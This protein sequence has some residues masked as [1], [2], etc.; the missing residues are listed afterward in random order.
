[1]LLCLES[2]TFCSGNCKNTSQKLQRLV[3]LR[4]VYLVFL[5]L[6]EKGS[7]DV[8]DRSPLEEQHN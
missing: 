7:K 8:C 3:V 6:E 2:H 5:K 4:G 1:M